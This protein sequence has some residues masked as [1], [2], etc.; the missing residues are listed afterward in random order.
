MNANQLAL[1][2]L[3]NC[4]GALRHAMA[5]APLNDPFAPQ[6][7]AAEKLAVKV[8]ASIEAELDKPKPDPD[9]WVQPGENCNLNGWIDAKAWS[10]GE[11]TL[12]LYK[13]AP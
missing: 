10:E 3:K 5:V 4:A 11:F 9:A 8:I 2:A 1:D 6:T 12:P 13:A 7:Q